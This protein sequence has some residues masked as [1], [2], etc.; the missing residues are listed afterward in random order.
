MATDTE[1]LKKWIIWQKQASK[2]NDV[3]FAMD[4]R[5]KALAIELGKPATYE[6]LQKDAQ[7]QTLKAQHDIEA[8]KCEQPFKDF[9]SIV[10]TA[11]E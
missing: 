10:K 11:V 3:S 5:Q 4:A 8:E 9:K 2:T 7:Y 1:I 6:D